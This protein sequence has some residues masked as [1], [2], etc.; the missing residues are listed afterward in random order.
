MQYECEQDSIPLHHTFYEQRGSPSRPLWNPRQ[1]QPHSQSPQSRAPIQPGYSQIMTREPNSNQ[2][3]QNSPVQASAPQFQQY[4]NQQQ[5]RSAQ[6]G[7][8]D[9][10][11]SQEHYSNACPQ[12]SK[13]QTLMKQAE[14]N[15][16]IKD[17][18]NAENNYDRALF[19]HQ[20]VGKSSETLRSDDLEA[21]YEIARK[22]R[23]YHAGRKKSANSTPATF[24]VLHT[25][26]DDQSADHVPAPDLL[27]FDENQPGNN[28][29]NVSPQPDFPSG[30]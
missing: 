3:Q 23:E 27:V 26:C 20:T 8:C 12:P 21:M 2:Q 10:C 14:M 24:P 18:Y 13:A 7:A 6:Q 28:Y 30:V 4:Q 25:E 9:R 17:F 11:G 22:I 19:V 29:K 5:A 1:G 15:L 16:D